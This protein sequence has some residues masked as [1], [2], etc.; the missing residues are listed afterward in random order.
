[1]GASRV[2]LLFF[3]I[4]I[5]ASCTKTAAKTERICTPGNYVFCRCKDR[6]EGTKLCDADGLGF[7]PCEGCLSGSDNDDGDP[8][9][10]PPPKPKPKP[11]SGPPPPPDAGPVTGT[12]PVAGELAISEIMYDPS[13]PEPTEEWFEVTNTASSARVL[14]GLTIRD[15]SGRTALVPA[16]PT[17]TLAP[18]GYYVIVRNKQ[19]AIEAG[20]PVPSIVF[21]YGEGISDTLGV[22]LANGASGGLSI[23]DGANPVAT[24]TY[25]GWFTQA[26]PGGASIQLK[27]PAQ[28]QVAAGWCLTKVAW[29]GVDKG[30]PGSATVCP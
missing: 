3:A 24:V 26:P 2:A 13:G 29:A 25:G 9:P 18:A 5:A 21:E 17:I 14:N 1:V 19:A 8:E 28:A 20:I 23:Y 4:G 15:A 10:D 22:L 11:D 7:S 6:S 30:T 16:S 12:K 27:V